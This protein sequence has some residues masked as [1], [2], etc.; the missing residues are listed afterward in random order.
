MA[1]LESRGSYPR[2]A[3]LVRLMGK[4]IR[5]EANEIRKTGRGAQG[6]RLIKTDGGDKVTSASLLDAE[7]QVEA[8][9]A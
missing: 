3:S 9:E 5:I 4:L 7:S 6:V 8:V 1:V 2:P